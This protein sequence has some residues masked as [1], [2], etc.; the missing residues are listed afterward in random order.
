MK[1]LRDR[2]HREMKKIIEDLSWNGEIHRKQGEI[3]IGRANAIK[4]CKIIFGSLTSIGLILSIF[5]D[6][7]ML[8][9]FTAILSMVPLLL[10]CTDHSKEFYNLNYIENR[11]L[12]NILDLRDKSISLL[13][14]ITYGINS[15]EENQKEMDRIILRKKRLY[16]SLLVPSKRAER[17]T[18]KSLVKNMETE[19]DEFFIPE[20]LRELREVTLG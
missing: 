1:E 15:A 8:R 2:Q 16:E 20:D 6:V 3:Y 19:E 4:V 10:S 14:D 7:S 17:I 12:N 5:I 18:G 9:V 11:D 13:Y